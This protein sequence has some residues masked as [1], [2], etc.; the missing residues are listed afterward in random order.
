MQAERLVKAVARKAGL[1]S[2]SEISPRWLSHAHA[3][4]MDRSAKIHLVQA[5]LGRSFVA[6]TSKYPHTP[7]R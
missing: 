6:T 1:T 4:Q 7:G 3:L 5:T 2:T